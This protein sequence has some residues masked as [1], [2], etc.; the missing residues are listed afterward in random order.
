MSFLTAILNFYSLSSQQT[1]YNLNPESALHFE[2]E[3]HLGISVLLHCVLT[4]E[5]YLNW[6]Y[7][8][9]DISFFL[10]FLGILHWHELLCGYHVPSTLSSITST[11]YWVLQCE[12]LFENFWSGVV[13]L[14]LGCQIWHSKESDIPVS[15]LKI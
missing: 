8:C 6:S 7:I 2:L 10:A 3:I 11:R 13:S 9:H 1:F 15:V 12:T 5:G 14:V 4:K